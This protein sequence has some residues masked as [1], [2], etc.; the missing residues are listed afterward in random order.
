MIDMGKFIA[1]CHIQVCTCELSLSMSRGMIDMPEFR[2]VGQEKWLCE[3]VQCEFPPL[4][5]LVLREDDVL[6]L[7]ILHEDGD[8]DLVIEPLLSFELSPN[9]DTFVSNIQFVLGHY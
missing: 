5:H 7:A 9:S 6:F 1:K 2:Q 4:I 3:T 8:G